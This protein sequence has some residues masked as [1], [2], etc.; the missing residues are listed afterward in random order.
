M[1]LTSRFYS[2]DR[3]LETVEDGVIIDP[4]QLKDA[5]FIDSLRKEWGIHEFIAEDYYACDGYRCYKLNGIYYDITHL[6][7][8]L[9]NSFNDDE[10]EH[11]F[12][13]FKDI[14][15]EIAQGKRIIYSG[16]Y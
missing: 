11:L 14:L 12:P 13:L 5:L 10:C 6:I 8:N 15:W 3:E 2:S 16:S 9:I 4:S 7:P 1:G